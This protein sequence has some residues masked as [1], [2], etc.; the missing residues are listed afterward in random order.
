MF[1]TGTGAGTPERLSI[2]EGDTIYLFNPAANRYCSVLMS[3]QTA[4]SFGM[5]RH[6]TAATVGNPLTVISGGCK[7]GGTNLNGGNL[8]LSSGE[9]TGSGTSSV[10]LFA[11]PGIAAAT[12][13]NTVERILTA[14]A[15]S[16][17]IGSGVAGVDYALTFD[18]ESADG[19]LTWMEDEA[20]FQTSAVLRGATSLYRRY[21]HVALAAVNP[22][23]SGATWTPPDGSTVGGWQ[24]NAA[25]EVLYLN[26]DIHADWDGATDIILEV[27]FEVN[28]DNSGGGAGDTV[29]LKF[30]PYYKGLT[31]AV[32]KT[33]T[34][35]VA[36]VV[37]A[38]ARYKQFKAT[39]T[40]NYDEVS[41]VVEA[42]DCLRGILNLETDTSEVDDIIINEAT[43]YYQTT[44][45]GIESGDT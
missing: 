2:R 44:H 14:A 3:G 5:D 21:Y 27:K 7:I 24:L 38:S 31:E 9:S 23:A 33:Q 22:G 4:R 19:T 8:W 17:T 45:V 29:D 11:Y 13:D 10:M 26:S 39:F 41:N 42:G 25:T 1:Y 36:T 28:F 12:A 43:I 30:V 32:T 20:W 15:R 6:S 16:V 40:I 37:G 34:V 35:E 18:G